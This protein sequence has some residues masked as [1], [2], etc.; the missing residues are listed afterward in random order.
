MGNNSQACADPDC[1]FM[2]VSQARSSS[3]IPAVAVSKYS[4][5]SEGQA[6]LL[7]TDLKPKISEIELSQQE[8]A[9]S[10]VRL[11]DVA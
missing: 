4:D 2:Q 8:G 6:E 9:S 5:V 7:V 1:L 11:P 3:E 10:T